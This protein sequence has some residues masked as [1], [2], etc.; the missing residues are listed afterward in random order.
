MK[1]VTL[2]IAAAAWVLL[3]SAARADDGMLRMATYDDGR[4]LKVRAIDDP[5]SPYAGHYSDY[6][7]WYWDN[8][9][10]AVTEDEKKHFG[11]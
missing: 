8:Y 9:A 3:A 5:Q 1:V 4:V 11:G 6:D 2:T 10:A 7:R